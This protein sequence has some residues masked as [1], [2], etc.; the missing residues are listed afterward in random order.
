[1][2][3]EKTKRYDE[4]EAA[5][6]KEELMRLREENGG[7]EDL[8][9]RM[10]ATVY[11]GENKERKQRRGRGGR[12]DG[13]DG[14]GGSGGGEGGGSGGGGGGS[15]GGGGVGPGETVAAR[16]RE[17]SAKE[18]RMEAAKRPGFRSKLT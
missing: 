2:T 6:A 14:A 8:L 17:H 7:V 5:K 18:E 4:A 15:G 12:R 1:M 11:H 3:F 10:R 9:E 16:H 13:Q